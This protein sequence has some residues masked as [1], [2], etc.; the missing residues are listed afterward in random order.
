MPARR[1]QVNGVD[2][3]DP[4]HTRAWRK[5]RDQVVAEEPTCRLRIADICTT[6]STTADHII[7]VT[8]RPDLALDRSNCRGACRPC[9][10]ARG[11]LPDA[12]LDHGST[13]TPDALSIFR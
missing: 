11:N 12:A 4:R 6:V 10:D 9:N 7:P 8:T 1:I 2:H 13:D 3:I 5:L